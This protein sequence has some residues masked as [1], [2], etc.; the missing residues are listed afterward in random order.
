MVGGNNL[1]V[2]DSPGAQPNPATG[3][4]LYD[5]NGDGIRQYV[6]EYENLTAVNNGGTQPAGISLAS[7]SGVSIDAGTS[8]SDALPASTSLAALLDQPTQYG[9]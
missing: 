1:P 5:S 2:D 4:I 9:A 3:Q 6:V 7:V 8:A